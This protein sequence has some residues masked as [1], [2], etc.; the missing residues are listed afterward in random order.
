MR[1]TEMFSLPQAIENFRQFYFSEQIY[2]RK[3][4]IWWPDPR[5]DCVC[6]P[7]YSLSFLTNEANSRTKWRRVMFNDYFSLICFATAQINVTNYCVMQRNRKA[8]KWICLCRSFPYP[9]S[10][11]GVLQITNQVT[12]FFFKL[13]N[14]EAYKYH[15]LKFVTHNILYYYSRWDIFMLNS[16][17]HSNNSPFQ[18]ISKCWRRFR[19]DWSSFPYLWLTQPC[20]LKMMLKGRVYY[21]K[22]TL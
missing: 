12:I 16:S 15:F 10:G 19:H 13:A 4:P 1:K 22:I 21:E 7:N 14:R 11:A 6:L 5:P 3:A 18:A 9:E 2:Y 20:T 17:Y 8:H